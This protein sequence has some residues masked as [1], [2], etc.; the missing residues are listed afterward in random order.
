M[1]K[2]ADTKQPPIADKARTKKTGKQ[3]KPI[4]K[5]APLWVPPGDIQQDPKV[6]NVT[7][8]PKNPPGDGECQLPRTEKRCARFVVDDAVP[9]LHATQLRD[10]VQWLVDEAWGGGYGPPSVVDLHAGS[11]SY[12]DKF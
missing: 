1:S 2:P 6:A 12:Q 8:A 10:M 7:C 4:P 9:S 5:P 11:I 3:S